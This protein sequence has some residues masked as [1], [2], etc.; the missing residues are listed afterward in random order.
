MP[1][2]PKTLPSM[3]LGSRETPHLRRPHAAA[4]RVPVD[5]GESA[6]LDHAARDV[7]NAIDRVF[8]PLDRHD[9]YLGWGVRL[10][11]RA[12]LPVGAR[13]VGVCDGSEVLFGPSWPI[14]VSVLALPDGFPYGCRAA[15]RFLRRTSNE[16]NTLPEGELLILRVLPVRRGCQ[17]STF[18]GFACFWGR[19]CDNFADPQ[20]AQP[21]HLWSEII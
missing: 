4:L 12:L 10:T 13:C 18:P 3:W 8:D 16:G 2:A 21:V 9:H 15:P 11:A 1:S 6:V 20:Q 17:G 7:G 19:K 5:P 14:S